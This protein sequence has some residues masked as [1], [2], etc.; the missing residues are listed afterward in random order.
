MSARALATCL[1][2]L[3]ALGVG[4]ASSSDVVFIGP[5][6]YAGPGAPDAVALRADAHGRVVALLARYPADGRLVHVPGAYALPGLG[7]A[8]VHLSWIARQDDALALAGLTSVEAV[9]TA[10]EAH[11]SAH[12]ELAVITGEGWDQTLWPGAAFPSAADLGAAL[13]RPAVLTRVD[14]HAIWLNGP[15]MAAVADY[16]AA[17]H[18]LPERIL[19]GPDGHATG[20]VVDPAELL[21]QRLVPAPRAA[22]LRRWIVAGLARCADAGLVEIHDMATTPADLAILQDLAAAGPLPVHVVTYLENG[23]AAFTWL[24]AHRAGP[25]A[26]GSDLEVRGIKLYADGA[27]GSRGAALKAPYSDEPGHSGQASPLDALVTA[28]VD[29]AR[30]GYDVAIHAI[31][32]LGND[33]ALTALE[34]AKKAA[35]RPFRGRVEHAQVIDLADL[36]R[37]AAGGFVASMQPT[38]ATSDMRWAEARLGPERIRG[39]YA[40]KTFLAAGVALAFGSDAPVEGFDPRLALWAATTRRTTAGE[41]AGGWRTSEAVSFDEAVR[42]MSAGVAYAAQGEAT[43]GRWAPGYEVAISAFDRDPRGDILG[44]HATATVRGLRVRVRE[45]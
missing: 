11:A 38:H 44:A 20:V 31:G 7:D 30:A 13:Q 18:A 16:L 3:S 41:P 36:P 40:W 4:C 9:R 8:H 45:P 42:A 24:G 22:D 15:A 34:A 14:G 1:V 27:L 2:A 5:R 39:A 6:F 10:L 25:V 19:R 37:F 32:D 17:D 26:P 28:A 12:P 33:H 29:A 23:K 43:R 35:T 21:L